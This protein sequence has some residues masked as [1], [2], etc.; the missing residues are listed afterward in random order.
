MKL[1]KKQ[2][3]NRLVVSIEGKLDAAS[4]PELEKALGDLAD[5][6]EL[7]FDL[8][9]LVYTS[10]AGLRVLLKAQKVMDDQG[11]MTVRNANEDVMDIFKET[12]FDKILDIEE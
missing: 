2:Y 10:S 9:D 7:I 3:G 6:E 11:E 5:V 8:K 1:T 12:G 4:S